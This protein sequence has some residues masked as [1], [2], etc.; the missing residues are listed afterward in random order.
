MPRPVPVECNLEPL[1]RDIRRLVRPATGIADQAGH[2]RAAAMAG[3]GAL[4]AA[5]PWAVMMILAY[6]SGV[7]ADL[8]R[9]GLPNAPSLA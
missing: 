2:A 4:A 9:H 3:V 7:V 5:A 1:A 8:A 6:P